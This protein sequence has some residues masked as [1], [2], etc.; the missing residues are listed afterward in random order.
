MYFIRMGGLA[1]VGSSPEMLVRVEG[2]RVET[3]PDRR[4][5]AARRERGGRSA[6]GRGAEAQREGAR[7]ARDARRSRP[8][9][10]RPRLRVRHRAR[11]AVH[12]ARALLARHA[13]GLDAST[14]RLAD[15]RDRLDALVAC[16]PAG[17]VSGA[18]KIRAMQII[19]ELEPTR[20]G[21]YA[22]AV[23]Y[24][25]FAGNLDFC[26][27]I[28]TITIRDGVARVQ[29]GAGIVADSNPGGGVRRDARQGAR[30]AAGARRWRRRGCSDGPADR[31][32]RLV[33]LQPR[34]VSRRARAPPCRCAATTRSRSTRSTALQPDAD[35][36]LA[37]TGPA[38][39]RRHLGRRRSGG[40]A[41]R[42]P[43]LGVCLGHQAHRHRV[44]R[45]GRARAAADARQDVVDRSTT[46]AASSR[47]LAAVRRR[48]LSLAGRRRAAAG[49]ARGRRRG[50]T[51]ARSW[52]CGTAT[53]PM[54]GVQFHPESVLT[55]E[56]SSCCSNFLE[57]TRCSPRCSRSCSAART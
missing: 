54:H 33:H 1:I 42:M 55:G 14:A 35:R 43:M 23:G 50:P 57:L 47:R 7:R 53:C 52:A 17:T 38:G 26:I 10:P 39:G 2:R 27:A 8:Q 49:R 20:R 37:G 11:A 19:A 6:A 4:H 30:A 36:D 22:G 13:P 9:R 56:G 16:F 31:Q 12:G 18:P 41:R 32:L 51:T 45:R 15:D 21:L 28:R 34:P 5:A 29:A 44:R 46:A 24:I 3:H 40:S 25:D 48:P